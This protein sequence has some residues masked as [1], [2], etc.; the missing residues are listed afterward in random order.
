MVSGIFEFQIGEETTL[1]KTGDGL[2]M[3]P[4]VL[5]GVKCSEEG[6]LIDTFSSIRENFLK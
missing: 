3:D 5:H 4:N 6:L 2:Y 1:V